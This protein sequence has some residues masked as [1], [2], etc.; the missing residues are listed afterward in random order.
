M[1]KRQR[2]AFLAIGGLGLLAAVAPG[3]AA[4]I[5]TP[6]A[7]DAPAAGQGSVAVQGFVVEDINWSLSNE[8]EVTKVT[9]EIFRTED[10]AEVSGTPGTYTC[11]SGSSSVNDADAT[12]RASLKTTVS[13]WYDCD[14]SGG[15]ADCD[16]KN[17]IAANALTEVEILAFDSTPPAS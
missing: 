1:R 2:F 9:F 5:Q 8:G 4:G 7:A 12:V 13:N 3:L 15:K 14:V 17:D 16:T 11:S 6:S 10:C